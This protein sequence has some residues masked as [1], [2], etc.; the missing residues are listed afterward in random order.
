MTSIFEETVQHTDVHNSWAK[1][2]SELVFGNIKVHE[3]DLETHPSI[4]APLAK[5]NFVSCPIIVS[6]L[7]KYPVLFIC[8]NSVQASVGVASVT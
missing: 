8:C 7:L 6:S 4:L 3:M 5:S 2:S 1:T